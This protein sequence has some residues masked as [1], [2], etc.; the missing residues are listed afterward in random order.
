MNKAYE[1]YYNTYDRL[2]VKTC[3]IE[4]AMSELGVGITSGTCNYAS[5]HCLED[6]E[7]N[8]RRLVSA[9]VGDSETYSVS[10]V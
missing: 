1:K 2:G 10:E 9:N 7:G 5:I 4:T 6:K 3:D 8:K